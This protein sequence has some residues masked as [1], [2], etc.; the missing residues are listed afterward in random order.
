MQRFTFPIGKI[1]VFLGGIINFCTFSG[2]ISMK[3]KEYEGVSTIANLKFYLVV[4]EEQGKKKT[5]RYMLSHLFEL[6]TK[7]DS[8]CDKK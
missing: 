8:F 3:P 5:L 7:K 4:W 6:T 1:I 2:V